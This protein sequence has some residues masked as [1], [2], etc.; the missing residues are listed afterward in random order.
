M[1]G[2]AGREQAGVYMRTALDAMKVYPGVETQVCALDALPADQL[3][4]GWEAVH[5]LAS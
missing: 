1:K 5:R 3:L 4:A 2:D